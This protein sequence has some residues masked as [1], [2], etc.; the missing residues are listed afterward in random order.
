MAF[1]RRETAIL[2]SGDFLILIA[3]LWVALALRN[4][5]M[6]LLG[7]F[8]TNLVPFV[9]VIMIS[10]AVFYIAGLYEKQTRLVKREMGT[11][12]LGAQVANAAIAA[13]VFFV[14]PLSIAPKTI[15][16]LYLVVS[17]FAISAWRLYRLRRERATDGATRA[18]LVA[19]GQA[20]DEV[21]D[22]VNGNDRYL[23]V[24]SSRI[25]P[26]GKN[27]ETLAAEI[28]DIL[29]SGVR[30]LV[31]DTRDPVVERAL[32]YLYRAMVDGVAFLA[33]AA[34]Y[35]DLFDRVPLAHIDHAWLL[36]C[37]PK[38]HTI[39]D[40]A[41]RLFDIVGALVGLLI[42]LP[43][44]M[45]AAILLRFSGGPAFI[46]TERIGRG[47]IPFRLVKLRTMLFDDHG[48]AELHK[49]NRVTSLGSFL[50]KSRID[51][52]PQLWNVLTG[53]LS[54]IGPRPELP[55]IAAVYDQEIPYYQVRH[56][57][58]PGLS[59]WAQLRDFDPP[60]GLQRHFRG[61]VGRSAELEQR[62]LF[63]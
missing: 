14:L 4:L 22:E 27:A 60:K 48:D 40:T 33:F 18:L 61:E 41:K 31:I 1:T 42:A 53:E 21:F 11:R 25:D 24:F 36:E 58:P 43:F 50:R 56:L 57:I 39:Y 46:R 38:R 13:I 34:F 10:L 29:R 9:P 32:P 16:L 54:F 20:A 37:L 63:T 49:Q 17:V 23:L 47:G 3:S 8:E 62:V 51:E 15:L 28:S 55:A 12:V 19:S 52:L 6:P 5:E 7:Y 44:I 59:G 35:E 30:T 45:V 2:I 26:A